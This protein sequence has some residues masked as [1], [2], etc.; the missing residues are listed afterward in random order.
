[1]QRRIVRRLLR[2]L[3]CHAAATGFERGRSIVANALPHASKAVVVRLDV[4][5]FFGSTRSRRVY[6]YFRAI[7]W[8]RDASRL[9][10][11]LC[12]FDGCLPQG[13]PTSPRLSN[14]VNFR[15]DAR[16]AGLANLG[17]REETRLRRYRDPRTGAPV[18]ADVPDTHPIAAYTRYA[19]DLTFSFAVDDPRA[20]RDLIYRAKRILRAE[21]YEPNGRK[22]RIH[23]RHARQ[24]VTGLVV[25]EEVNLP[26]TTRR[27]LRAVRHRLESG[28]PASLTPG[29]LAGWVSFWRMVRP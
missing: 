28:R 21:G 4:K 20:I 19:D 26:R 16:L 8:N 15:L 25:N 7:G 27:W 11:R 1:L 9:L 17:A 14:L 5:D 10:L 2:R 6:R 12:T 22:Q 23:R 18:T 24:L 3:R 29:Q 13:A